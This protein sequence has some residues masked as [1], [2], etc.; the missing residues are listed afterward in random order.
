MQG[1]VDNVGRFI[2]V[3][4]GWPGRVHDVCQLVIIQEGSGW[5]TLPQLEADH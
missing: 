5:Y 1:M 4:I 3:Y 2:Q